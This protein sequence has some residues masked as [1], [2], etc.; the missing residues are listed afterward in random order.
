VAQRNADG[1]DLQTRIL[2]PLTRQSN[3]NKTVLWVI[4]SAALVLLIV[5]FTM[6][7]LI[8]KAAAL[9]VGLIGAMTGL[10]LRKKQK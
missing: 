6:P 8:G 9:L 3:M 2:K 10:F 7:W 4:A 1:A 5:Y